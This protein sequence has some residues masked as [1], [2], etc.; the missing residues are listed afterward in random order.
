[1]INNGEGH[2]TEG[3]TAFYSRKA[4]ASYRGTTNGYM[5]CMLLISCVNLYSVCN[6]C[7]YVPLVRMH[8]CMHMY[9]YVVWCARH[10]IIMY[11]KLDALSLALSLSLSFSLSLFLYA[12]YACYLPV[13]IT[14]TFC[15]LLICRT[16]TAHALMLLLNY[17][18]LRLTTATTRY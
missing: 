1:M 2:F 12:R 4:Y 13:C 3:Q 10:K 15:M 6:A 18:P 8:A 14:K 16:H 5:E 7:V 17:P 11:S 9:V